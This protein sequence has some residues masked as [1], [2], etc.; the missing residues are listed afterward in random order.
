MVMLAN[1]LKSYLDAQRVPY[2]VV[3]HP[4]DYTAQQAA[5]DT[6]TPGRLFA[7]VVIA[8]FDST[9]TMLVL[10]ANHH[11]N[12]AKLRLITGVHYAVLG[13]E[14]RQRELFSDCDLGAEPPFGNLYGLPVIASQALEAAETITFNAG[15]HEDAV[16]MK[17]ADYAR[18]VQPKVLDFT[19]PVG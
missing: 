13:Q 19:E 1:R 9:P 2:E 6:R 15:S 14:A 17:Y 8:L 12:F 3:H 10:P 4:P 7:K 11:V 18:L 16:R 5:Q